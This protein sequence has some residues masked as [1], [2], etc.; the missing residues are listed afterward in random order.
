M[1]PMVV[2]GFLVTPQT[3]SDKIEVPGTLMPAE[4]TQIRAEVS[5]RVVRLNVQEGT[6]VNKGEILVKLFDQICRP[7]SK[8]SGAVGDCQQK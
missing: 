1:G 5:G 8:T 4:E 3:I 7:T 2:D 6:T